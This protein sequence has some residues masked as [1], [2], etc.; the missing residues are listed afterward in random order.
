MATACTRSVTCRVQRIC[1]TPLAQASSPQHRLL[2]DAAYRLLRS[3]CCRM[4][5]RMA[6]PSP[7]TWLAPAH[8]Q[9]RA[10]I[11]RRFEDVCK[12]NKKRPPR[13]LVVEWWR[14]S[15]GVGNPTGESKSDKTAQRGTS[16]SRSGTPLSCTKRPALSLPLNFTRQGLFDSC[17]EIGRGM[18]RKYLVLTYHEP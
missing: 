1:G 3:L 9:S 17:T 2:Q 16:D 5:R 8:S 18:P 11:A 14:T 12:L 6:I 4:P 10:T 13:I 7:G 15:A